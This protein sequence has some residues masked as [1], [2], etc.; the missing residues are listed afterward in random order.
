L[1]DED[2]IVIGRVG[3]LR[4]VGS[5]NGERITGAAADVDDWVRQRGLLHA[6]DHDD[7]EGI[8][9][10]IRPGVIA[11]DADR[12]AAKARR[13]GGGV[14]QVAGCGLENR[15]SRCFRHGSGAPAQWREK[16]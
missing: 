14:R 10:G 15:N 12:A 6:R 5:I 3:F 16:K 9:A 11:R 4:L 13:D 2:E 7:G 1:I 8:A